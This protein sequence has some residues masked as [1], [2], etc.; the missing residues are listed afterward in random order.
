MTRPAPL[1]YARVPPF[2]PVPTRPRAD[3]WTPLRQAE[4]IGMLAQTGSVSKAAAFVGMAR[5]TAYRLRAKPGADSFIAAWDAALRV[6]GVRRAPPGTARPR[7]VTQAEPWRAMIGTRWRVVIRSGRYC[8]SVQEAHNSAVLAHLRQI[9]R[10]AREGRAELRR[11]LRSQPAKTV[12]RVPG[13][14][15]R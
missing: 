3:G 1:P 7:K 6:A 2:T 9:D 13:G 8:G 5:E 15:V 10:A 14:S 12:F 4:F 11:A